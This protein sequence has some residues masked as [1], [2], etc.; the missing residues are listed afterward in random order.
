MVSV[1]LIE[2]ARLGEPAALAR[3]IAECRPDVRRSAR[4]ACSNAADAE[5]AIQEA[6]LVLYRNIG[7]LRAVA[8]FSRWLKTIVVRECLRLAR[9][10]AGKH[11][12]LGTV[13]NDLRLSYR[14]ADQLRL[15]LA[16]AI[17]SLPPIHREALLLRDFEELTMKEIAA[18]LGITVENAKVRL[19]RARYLVRE[20]LLK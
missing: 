2:A 14:S 3:L 9:R 5:D 4:R 13:E 7:A 12:E 20:Y 8:A 19:H 17:G 1:Q 6:S 10:F 15:E 11:V 18:R 16:D